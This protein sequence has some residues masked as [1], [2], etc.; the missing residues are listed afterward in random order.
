MSTPDNKSLY[1]GL[2]GSVIAAILFVLSCPP[3]EHAAAAW[4]VPGILLVSARRL[5][6]RHAFEAGFLFGVLSAGM[7]GRW[8]PDS[9]V[10][11]FELTPFL[12]SLI[13]YGG[14]SIGIG[15]PCGLLTLGYAYA[16]RRVSA[17]DLPIVGTFFWIAAEWL[18][19]QY[20]GWAMLGH[21]QFRELWLIQ[22]ADLGG[23]FAVSFVMAL[24]SI[25]IAEL[26][27][28]TAN[29]AVGIAAGARALILPV[30][31][32]AVSIQYGATAREIYE[33]SP[34]EAV[35]NVESFDSTTATVLPASWN[36]AAAP[37]RII[38]A[39]SRA[40]RGSSV[41]LPDLRVRQV[42]TIQDNGVSVSPLLCQ[43]LLNGDLVHQV[44]AAGADVLINN[45]RVPWMADASSGAN[46][47]H[48][49]VAVFRSV[50][51]RRFLVRA[52]NDGAGEL[53]TADGETHREKPSGQS[54][55]IAEGTTNYLRYG[56]TW[57]FAG[58]GLALIV[59][60]RGRRS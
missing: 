21:S 58:F 53:I 38:P 49:A 40:E 6:Y 44:V 19:D 23:V 18:R 33:A 4:L 52:T 15:I 45:C 36:P 48:L 60:G 7:V 46:A 22:V 25:S 35:S 13:A 1:V 11:G 56:N 27:S 10:L 3:F 41:G 31:A 29:R 50:E 24:V 32:L 5:P 9:L 43:D 55:A 34:A 30:A 59:V 57:I 2:L 54:L 14:I 28:A 17:V 42:S 47:Q 37:S 16:S 51:S 39:A 26:I 20:L 12:A 8:L